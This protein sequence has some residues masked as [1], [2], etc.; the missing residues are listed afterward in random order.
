MNQILKIIQGPNAGA[1]IALVEGVNLKLGRGDECDIILADQTLPNVACEIETGVNRV[2]LLLPGGTQEV[3]EPLHV[4]IFGTTAIAIG[5]DDAPWGTL[6]WP[7][8]KEAEDEENA[9][10]AEEAKL[11]EEAERISRRR[12]RL[13]KLQWVLLVVLIL[14]VALE[15]IL[16]FFWPTINT[17]MV[18]GRSW[19][20]E[21][22]NYITGHPTVQ[23]QIN[24]DPPPSLNDMEELAK[25]YNLELIKNRFQARYL[26]GNLK[27]RADRLMVTAQAYQ[28]FPGITLELT[29]DE[30]LR[31]AAEEILNM[32]DANTGLKIVKAENRQI[33]LAGTIDSLDNLKQILEAMETDIVHL[34]KIDC[35]AVSIIPPVINTPVYGNAN[36]TTATAVSPKATTVEE[37]KDEETQESTEI[38]PAVTVSQASIDMPN[39]ASVL[40]P[41]MPIVGIMLQPVPCLILKN[42]SRILE[43]AEFN[44]FIVREIRADAVILYQNGKTLEWQP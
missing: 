19:C 42:G 32:T 8:S 25:G 44:G 7:N 6:I 5:P 11:A 33:A 16:W 14:I 28:A 38:L 31:N 9:K 39:D 27:T 10:A 29:D 18:Q 22:Y 1:E 17:W 41:N 20:T 34:K 36:N 40:L 43:G 24:L 30:T 15:F 12:I 4:K 2:N 13:K 3:L 26:K 23:N 37:S 35:S 21:Q